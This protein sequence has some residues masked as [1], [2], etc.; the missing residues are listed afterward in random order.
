[1]RDDERAER[2]GAGE[3]TPGTLLGAIQHAFDGRGVDRLRQPERGLRMKDSRSATR[4]NGA[5]EG[6][7]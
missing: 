1:M 5:Q 6:V 4:E 7:K 2:P 3:T